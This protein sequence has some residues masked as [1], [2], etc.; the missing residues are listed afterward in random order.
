[1]DWESCE[2]RAEEKGTIKNSIN[3]VF[4]TDLQNID[5]VLAFTGSPLAEAIDAVGSS[6]FQVDWSDV[7]R[8]DFLIDVQR[9]ATWKNFLVNKSEKLKVNNEK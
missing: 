1:M 7:T 2:R 3:A 4:G 9:I 8:G 6:L 5:D